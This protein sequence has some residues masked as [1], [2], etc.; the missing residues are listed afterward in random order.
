MLFFCIYLLLPP[1]EGEKSADRRFER[2]NRK[3]SSE[4]RQEVA[5]DDR[6]TG[7]SDDRVWEEKKWTDRITNKTIVPRP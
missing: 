3:Y 7:Q 2:S 4:D 1:L 6:G 5:G